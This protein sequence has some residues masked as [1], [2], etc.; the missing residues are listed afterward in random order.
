MLSTYHF[1]RRII[2]VDISNIVD[3]SFS[4]DMPFSVDISF[5][6]VISFAADISNIVDIKFSVDISFCVKYLLDLKCP[7]NALGT[8]CAYVYDLYVSREKCIE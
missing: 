5:S 1:G 7:D 6:V 4:F 8:C 3:I 2:S